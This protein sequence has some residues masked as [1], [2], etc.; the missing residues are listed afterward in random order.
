MFTIAGPIQTK[1]ISPGGPALTVAVQSGQV[2]R[3]LNFVT[4]NE[5]YS[6]PAYITIGSQ[7]ANVIRA[8]AYTTQETRIVLN[9][10]G[11]ATLRVNPVSIYRQTISYKVDSNL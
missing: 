3:I 10:A 9:L 6:N 4:E 5:T 7:V 1:I 2:L 8:T 11:P